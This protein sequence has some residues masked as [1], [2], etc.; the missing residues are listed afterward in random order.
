MTN[1]EACQRRNDALFD[2]RDSTD[3]ASDIYSKSQKVYFFTIAHADQYLN[4]KINIIW[5]GEN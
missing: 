2:A 3:P 1:K 4:E 5:I